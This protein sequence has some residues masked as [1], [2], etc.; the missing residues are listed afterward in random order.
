MKKKYIARLRNYISA[1]NSFIRQQRSKHKAK[2]RRR[3]GHHYNAK[4]S[5]TH[6][7]DKTN[8]TDLIVPKT[9]CLETNYD[10][11]VGLL[12]NLRTVALKERRPVRLVFDETKHITA[13]A[14]LRVLAEIHRCRLVRGAHLVS[15]TY[16]TEEKLER[17]LSAMGFFEILGV[18]NRLSIN[19]THPMNYIKFAS[20]DKLV[21]HQS[22]HL[23]TELLGEKIEMQNRAK[24][25]LQRAITEAMLNA[26]EHAYPKESQ[27]SHPGKSRWWLG[28]T[29]NRATKNLTIM[30]CDLGVG[31][32][33]TVTKLY[34][35][36]HIRA[37][38]SILPGF[39]VDDGD[40]IKAAMALGRTRTGKS[41][42]GKGLNDLKK[43]IDLAGE[44][45]LR[46]YSKKG[47]YIYTAGGCEQVE[48]HR[49]SIGG[50]LIKWRV[51]IANVTDWTGEEYDEIH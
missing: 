42:R 15:G 16:P 43:F 48:N 18:R 3:T 14:L 7:R 44:G 17:M 47:A 31:I 22:R 4:R 21:E 50:T 40:M 38:L 46:I 34:L 24:M 9:L 2:S 36:E 8:W 39:P 33:A 45:E 35:I 5:S 19:R 12:K 13:S 49:L 29:F 51:P 25:S 41:T 6:F 23:R 1:K 20:S 28:G 26:I 10:E 32:P 11:T 27:K 37:V 30:F